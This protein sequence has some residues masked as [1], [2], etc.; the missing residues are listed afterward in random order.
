MF[1]GMLRPFLREFSLIGLPFFLR[2]LP[3]N[4]F[5]LRGEMTVSQWLRCPTKVIINRFLWKLFLLKSLIKGNHWETTMWRLSCV[6]VPTEQRPYKFPSKHTLSS[7]YMGTAPMKAIKNAP[8]V[9]K[10]MQLKPARKTTIIW[11]LLICSIAR[12]TLY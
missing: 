7:N 11:Q 3:F 4:V 1:K 9:K 2:T 10:S 12:K 8:N 5:F 6:I